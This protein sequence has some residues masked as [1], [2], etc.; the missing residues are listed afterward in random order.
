MGLRTSNV[1]HHRPPDPTL[2]VHKD[3]S[4]TDTHSDVE[5]P[6]DTDTGQGIKEASF[7]PLGHW[8]K[9]CAEEEV[10]AKSSIPPIPQGR[11]PS[12]RPYHS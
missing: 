5:S 6:S 4:R 11:V 9:T 3:I 1:K 8:K 2:E 7:V 10:H 12:L